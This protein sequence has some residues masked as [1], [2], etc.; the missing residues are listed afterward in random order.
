MRPL[1]LKEFAQ[2][3]RTEGHP[4]ADEI[5]DLLDLETE[6]AEPY[7]NLCD[8]LDHYVPTNPGRPD[9]QLEW[10]GDRSALL[11]EIQDEL[12]KSDRTGDVDDIVKEMIS[13]LD[14]AE[15]LL[16]QSQ[17]LSEGGDFLTAL[18]TVLGVAKP[19]MEYDL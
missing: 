14:Q 8:D 3:L 13:T 6:V 19:Q 4:F 2:A 17:W 12:A 11:S 16:M 7:G 10:L 15:A 1:N 5:L 9:K 18:E